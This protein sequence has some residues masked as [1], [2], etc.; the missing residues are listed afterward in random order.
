MPNIT[1]RKS[2]GGEVAKPQ[3]R[4]EWEPMRLIHDLFHWDPFR[5]IAPTWPL[6]SRE[7][8]A[9]AFEV[10]E[11]PDSYLFKADVPGIKDKNI[12]VTLTGD[13][14][15]IAG[16]RDAETEDEGETYYAY[17]RSYG[18]FFRAFTLPE[19]ADFDHIQSELREGVLTVVVPKKPGAQPKKIEVKVSEKP[20]S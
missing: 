2:N 7:E 12:E 9:P 16:R 8:F 19:G 14:L 6:A 17:E 10:K 18:R 20:K 11:T 3:A 13:R 15:S 1:V 4:R 5:E